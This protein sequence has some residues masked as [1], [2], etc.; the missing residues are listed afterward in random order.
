VIDRLRAVGKWVVVPI[1]M[2]ALKQAGGK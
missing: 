2:A 1:R